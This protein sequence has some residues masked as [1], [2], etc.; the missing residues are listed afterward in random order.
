MDLVTTENLTLICKSD[1]L[2]T[3]ML[4]RIVIS[5]EISKKVHYFDKLLNFNCKHKIELI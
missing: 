4:P 3:M 2:G 1:Q 5:D